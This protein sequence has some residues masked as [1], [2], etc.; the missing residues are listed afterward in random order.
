MLKGSM[1]KFYENCRASSGGF[2]EARTIPFVEYI[3]V[4]NKWGPLLVGPYE[5]LTVFGGLDRAFDILGSCFVGGLSQLRARR[6]SIH[7]S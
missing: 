3:V 2:C 4:S 7:Q 1:V 5:R 6:A